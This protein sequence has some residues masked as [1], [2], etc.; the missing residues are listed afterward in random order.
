MSDGKRS[1]TIRQLGGE[2]WIEL[3]AVVP[4]PEADWRTWDTIIEV[5]MAV[6]ARHAGTTIENDHDLPVTPL[7][8]KARR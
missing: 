3:Q 6:L 1:R 4:E 2:I 8:G 7:P 5:V